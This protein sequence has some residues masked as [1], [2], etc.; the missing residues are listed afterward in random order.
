MIILAVVACVFAIAFVGTLLWALNK[1]AE[2]VE[3]DNQNN[4]VQDEA[5]QEETETENIIS[6]NDV[7][8]GETPWETEM[9]ALASFLSMRTDIDR[10]CVIYSFGKIQDSLIAPYQTIWGGTGFND[11]EGCEGGGGAG[12]AF[13]RTS[14][15]ADWQFGFGG[16]EA[17]SC[18]SLSIDAKRA[19]SDSSCFANGYSELVPIGSLL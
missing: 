10:E 17:P 4:V 8:L 3:N 9:S 7:S 15:D 16:H 5:Q 14:P 2:V 19:F 6:D 18:D 1:E 11:A 13:Y 12:I